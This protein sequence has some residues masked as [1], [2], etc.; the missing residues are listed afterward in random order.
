MHKILLMCVA[1]LALA[2]CSAARVDYNFASAPADAPEAKINFVQYRGIDSWHVV[3]NR[4][5][6]VLARGRH[7]WYEVKLFA[8][9]IDLPFAMG[10]RFLPSDGAGSFDR[11]SS[12][13]VRGETCKVESVKAVQPPERIVSP[14]GAVRAGRS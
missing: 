1:G 9:C 4:L 8:P 13:R 5:L 6:Y 7:D 14:R 2:A 12:I 11:F 10:I 3:N